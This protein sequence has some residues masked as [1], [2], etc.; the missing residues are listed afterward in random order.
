MTTQQ[1][2][3]GRYPHVRPDRARPKPGN[4]RRF[5][6]GLSRERRIMLA[7]AGLAIVLATLVVPVAAINYFLGDSG[8]AL[9]VEGL[10]VVAVGCGR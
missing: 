3:P 2:S 4:V 6:D 10:Q 1:P 8:Y 7:L 9:L 5:W